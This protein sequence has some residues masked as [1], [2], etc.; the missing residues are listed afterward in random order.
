MEASALPHSR[1]LLSMATLDSQNNHYIQGKSLEYL[2]VSI[3]YN[4]VFD[5]FME[6]YLRNNTM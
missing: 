4:F 3:N 6:K 2:E 1:L 5:H